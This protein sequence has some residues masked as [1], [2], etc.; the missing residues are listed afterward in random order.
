MEFWS[1]AE[2]RDR[3]ISRVRTQAQ[4]D[5][6]GTANSCCKESPSSSGFTEAWSG[7]FDGVPWVG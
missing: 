5:Y 7:G 4:R 6:N 2:S 3:L 1:N